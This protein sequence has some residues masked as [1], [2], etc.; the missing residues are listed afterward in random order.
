MPEIN[1]NSR[2][3][4]NKAETPLY[5]HGYNN[6]FQTPEGQTVNIS[7]PNATIQ[8]GVQN[9][10]YQYP[11]TSLYA[12]SSSIYSPQDKNPPD[13]KDNKN[14]KK[15]TASGVNIY[16]YNPSGIGGPNSSSIENSCDKAC[17]MPEQPIGAADISNDAGANKPQKTKNVVELTDDY[18]KTLESYLRSNDKSVRKMGIRD[19]INRFEEDKSRY[20]DP[21]LTALL[22][23]ALQ[24]SDPANRLLAISPIAAAS[25]HGDENTVA[26]LQNL[27]KSDKLYGQEAEMAAEALLKSSQ[28]KT[29]APDD[30]VE[31][32]ES[33]EQ[34]NDESQ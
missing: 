14:S 11:Q 16:I 24:D 12:P 26:L 30:S 15:N 21:A 10:I 28:N 32:A 31:K 34:K 5:S 20:D 18:I 17:A 19:L 6:S 4:R 9:P 1:T 22:N 13:N 7:S 33:D 29:E 2:I 23:I 8:S 27:T 25:A 3:K